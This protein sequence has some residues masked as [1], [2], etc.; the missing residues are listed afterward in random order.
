MTAF[1]EDDYVS[2]RGPFGRVFYFEQIWLGSLRGTMVKNRGMR[3]KGC[4]ERGEWAE[5]CFMARAAGQGLRVSK[6]YGDSASYDVGVECVAPKREGRILR[7]Q[8]K[9]TVYKRRGECYSLNVMGAHRERYPSGVVDFFAI[10]LIPIDTWYIIPY[11]VMGRTNCTLH[12]TPGSKRQKYAAYR[13]A[14][15]LLRGEEKARA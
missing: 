15:H 4:K 9:S 14:W 6:P 1:F 8:V 12:F 13:E 10:Y 5:L 11:E 7:V 3:I 2:P